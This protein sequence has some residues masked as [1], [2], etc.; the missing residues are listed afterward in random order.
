MKSDC[1]SKNV[2]GKLR[3]IGRP[4]SFRLYSK[5]VFRTFSRCE[6]RSRYGGSM[7]NSGWEYY[8][9]FIRITYYMN[10]FLCPIY[11]RGGSRNSGGGGGFWAGILQGGVRV[12][13]HRNFHILTSKTKTSEG[14]GLN[15]LPPPGSA[16]VSIFVVK[17]KQSGSWVDP[18]GPRLLVPFFND[19]RLCWLKETRVS[20]TSV[21][22]SN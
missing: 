16:T 6:S 9:V 21:L 12:Q 1:L 22:S 2:W 13:V 4:S 15:P 3:L 5:R 18:L 11:P 20:P 17:D 10:K 8:W 19:R 7:T 14:G